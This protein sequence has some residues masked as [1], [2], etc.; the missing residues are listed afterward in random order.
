MNRRTK[1]D[2][3]VPPRP[4]G[5][6]PWERADWPGFSIGWPVGYVPRAAAEQ[7]MTTM[8]LAKVEAPKK[9]KYK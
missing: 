8:Q 7:Q 4:P 5:G 2:F 1:D 9:G 6:F 3:Y